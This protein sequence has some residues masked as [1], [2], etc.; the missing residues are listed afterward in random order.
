M[1]GGRGLLEAWYVIL[2]WES[3][4]FLLT[5]C[6]FLFALFVRFS[7]FSLP[8][9]YTITLIELIFVIIVEHPSSPFFFRFFFFLYKDKIS[10]CIC[11]M[12]VQIFI[13]T[14]NKN[15]HLWKVTKIVASL[16]KFNKNI[17]SSL[18]LL[19]F[20]IELILRNALFIEFRTRIL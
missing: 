10:A 12:L 11:K 5:H 19:L 1:R 8:S 2:Y 3:I 4:G 16:F 6:I 17:L 7:F 13:Q 18:F 14:R 15:I 20:R 9:F